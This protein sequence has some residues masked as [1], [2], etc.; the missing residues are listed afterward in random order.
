MTKLLNIA[1]TRQDFYHVI[2][3][4]CGSAVLQSC[5]PEYIHTP[6]SL[7]ISHLSPLTSHLSPL[8]STD[9]KSLPGFPYST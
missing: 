9:I 2:K 5:S 7:L 6:Y 1:Q 3:K 8:F 4:F